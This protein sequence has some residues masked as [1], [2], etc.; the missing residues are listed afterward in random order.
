MVASQA[1]RKCPGTARAGWQSPARRQ[2]QQPI[3]VAV[4]GGRQPGEHVGEPGLRFGAVGLGRGNEAHDRGTPFRRS[5]GAGKQPVLAGD[6]DRADDA[7]L[8]IIVDRVAAVLG[9]ACESCPAIKGVRDRAGKSGVA[10][11]LGGKVSRTAAVGRFRHSV[12]R[13]TV[14]RLSTEAARHPRLFASGRVQPASAEGLLVPQE[15]LAEAC[16]R[17]RTLNLMMHR[18][19]CHRTEL[20]QLRCHRDW[21]QRFAEVRSALVC[22][23]APRFAATIAVGWTGP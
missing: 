3:D 4:F 23:T 7:L 18:R 13:Q 11:D 8:G 15:A 10:K 9:H 20:L 2:W 14:K 1:D 21:Q 6:R 16:V 12:A 19:L 22:L 17:S 5:L